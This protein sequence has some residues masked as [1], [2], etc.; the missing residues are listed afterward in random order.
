MKEEINEI[1]ANLGNISEKVKRIEN[2]LRKN[3]HARTKNRYNKSKLK[4]LY[5]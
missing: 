3:N 1:K 5:K 2:Q 4:S